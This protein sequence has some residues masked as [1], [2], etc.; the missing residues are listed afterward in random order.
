MVQTGRGVKGKGGG[1]LWV[2]VTANQSGL[3]ARWPVDVSA[4]SL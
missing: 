3:R 4:L 1:V 2:D